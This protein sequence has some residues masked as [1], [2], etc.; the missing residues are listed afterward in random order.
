MGSDHAEEIQKLFEE[1]RNLRPE[2]WDH[3]LD[4]RCGDEGA[5]REELESLLAHHQASSDF[6][7]APDTDPDGTLPRPPGL[8]GSGGRPNT[9]D[10]IGH[11]PVVPDYE[12]FRSIGRGGFGEVWLSCSKLSR[13]YC[14]IKVIHRHRVVELEG[15]REYQQRVEDHPNFVPILHVGETE[16]FCYCVMPLADN[17][18]TGSPPVID[19]EAYRPL[20]LQTYLRRRDHLEVDEAIHIVDEVLTALEHLHDKGAIHGDVKPANIF[21]MR[22]RWCLGDVGLVTSTERAGPKGHTREY[23]PPEGPGGR[24]GDLYALGVTLFELVTGAPPQRLPDF[25]AGTLAIPAA[26]LRSSPLGSYILRATDMDPE[27]RFGAACYMRSAL[28]AMPDSS[29]QR[30]KTTVT[31]AG[32]VRTKRNPGRWILTVSVT[33]AVVVLLSSLL[34]PSIVRRLWPDQGGSTTQAEPTEEPPARASVGASVDADQESDGAADRGDATT[35]P[36]V[37]PPPP[38][39][40]QVTVVDSW[41]NAGFERPARP[42]SEDVLTI[43]VKAD[44]QGS[45]YLFRLGPD[46]RIWVWPPNDN[47][48]SET[49]KPHTYARP[50]EPQ[51][52]D[53][54]PLTDDQPG[55]YCLVAVLTGEALDDICRQF[56]GR[57]ILKEG[58]AFDNARDW[59]DDEEQENAKEKIRPTIQDVLNASQKKNSILGF[60][61]FPYPKF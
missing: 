24:L 25:R 30:L 18:T 15:I 36:L 28:A 61:I 20:T 31:T 2:E 27:R 5:L 9:A 38:S 23:T 52:I 45:F 47:A 44:R 29:A 43:Y 22:E 14:A 4:D 53:S 57:L 59:R 60:E 41:P 19:L 10:P 39:P 7:R 21:R 32:T 13:K 33:F 54:D 8:S 17:A 58:F 34:L 1:A 42:G 56:D 16:A 6:M 11:P 46:G 26:D 12:L 37:P 50:N 35:S 55:A 40:A 49:C 3:F 51:R 48:G